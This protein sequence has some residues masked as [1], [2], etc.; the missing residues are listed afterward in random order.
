MA[1][2][3]LKNKKSKSKS[4]AAH[5]EVNMNEEMPVLNIRERVIGQLQHSNLELSENL[6]YKILASVDPHVFHVL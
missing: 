4:D 5:C 1:H 3:I 6:A 2:A